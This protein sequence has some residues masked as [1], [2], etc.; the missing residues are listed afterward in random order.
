MSEGEVI[1]AIV[2]RA[3]PKDTEMTNRGYPRYTCRRRKGASKAT[4]RFNHLRHV[5]WI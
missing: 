2:V 1:G 5:R 3:M 4:A